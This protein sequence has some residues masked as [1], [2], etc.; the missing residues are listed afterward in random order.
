LALKVQ[1]LG[2]EQLGFSHAQCIKS[3]CRSS[4]TGY[5]MVT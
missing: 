1:G 4:G 2:I 5:G 3:H